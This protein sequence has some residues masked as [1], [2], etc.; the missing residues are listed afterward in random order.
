M[1]KSPWLNKEFALQ[2]LERIDEK[3]KPDTA[4]QVDYLLKKMNLVRNNKI[5]DL[6]CGAGRHAIEFA[7]KGIFV[8][9]VDISDVMLENAKKRTNDEKVIVNYIQCSLANLSDL[10][11]KEESYNGAICLCESGVGVIGGENKDLDFFKQVYK[12]LIPNS[13]F[14]LTCLNSLRRYIRSRDQNPNFDYIN[15][16]I[17]WAPSIEFGGEELSEIERLYAPSEIK[18]ILELCGFSKIQILSCNDGKFSDYKMGID[19]IEMLVSAKKC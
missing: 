18:M 6:G 10:Q 7:K 3:F 9:G 16:T 2:S 12:L 14:V 8:T 4:N 19:D 13:Y 5:L 11:L 17:I 1:F 15:S